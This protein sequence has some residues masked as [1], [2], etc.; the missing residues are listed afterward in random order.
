MMDVLR[1]VAGVEFPAF[2]GTME[3]EPAKSSAD[4]A[5][6][7]PSESVALINGDSAT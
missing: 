3:P 5:T 1:S 2:L 7:I 4:T 6:T